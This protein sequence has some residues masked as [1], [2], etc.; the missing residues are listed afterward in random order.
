MVKKVVLFKSYISTASYN[1]YIESILSYA[2]Q[3]VSSYVCFANAHMLTEANSNPEFNRIVND[4]DIVTPD[5]KPISVLIRLRYG[6]KQERA[7]GMDMFPEILKQAEN[8]ELSVFFYG[9]TDEVLNKIKEKAKKE[10]PFLKIAGAYSPPF[11]QLTSE[12]DEEVINMINN[13]EANLVFVSLG[14]PKQEIWMNQHKGKINSCMLGLG[15]AFLTYSGYEKRLPKWARNLS[16]EWAYRFYL[17]PK[18]LWKR[19]FF[20][21]SMFLYLSWKDLFM[22]KFRIN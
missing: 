21:N 15:Q 14:C 20:G 13:S 19:Y 5:G 1:T 8:K 18:R 2:A 11:R 17:E 9:S 7:C 16:L 4:A 22:Q 6:I 12:E 3:R 10:F